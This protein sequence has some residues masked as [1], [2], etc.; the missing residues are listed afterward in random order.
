MY[1]LVLYGAPQPRGEDVVV[2]SLLAVHTGLHMS[3]QQQLR[4][5]RA[6]VVVTLIAVPDGGRR[7]L[8]CSLRGFQDE[9][10]VQSLIQCP[11]SNRV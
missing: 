3:R 5:R 11:T 2:G 6:G 4:I 9:G 10:H 7:L 8:Q 1:V